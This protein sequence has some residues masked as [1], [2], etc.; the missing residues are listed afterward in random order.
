MTATKSILIVSGDCPSH[1]YACVKLATVLAVQHNITVAGPTSMMLRLKAETRKYNKASDVKNEIKTISVGSFRT[2]K[3]CNIRQVVDPQEYSP[4]Q[5]IKETLFNKDYNPF[6]LPNMLENMMDDQ[7]DTF[8]KI[9]ELL[10]MYDLVYAVHS[11]APTVIDAAETLEQEGLES[12]PRCVLF[13]SLPYEPSFCYKWLWNQARS[14]P[15]LP[16]VATYSSPNQIRKICSVPGLLSYLVQLFW[17]LLDTYLAERAWK[18]AARR[19]DN[20]RATRGLSPVYDGF[21]YYWMKYPVLSL[22]GMKPY[23]TDEDY[24][25]NSTTVVGSIQSAELSDLNRLKDWFARENFD[26]SIIY[27]G[28]GTGTQLS[29]EESRNLALLALSCDGTKYHLLLSLQKVDQVRLRDVFDQVLGKP[30]M[31]DEDDGVL[32]Y[33]NGLLRIDCDVPQENLLASKKVSMFIS[34]MGFG[35]FTEAVRGGVPMVSYPAGCDQWFNAE[36]AVEAG[37][38]V[39]ANKRMK[40]LTE[41]V[42]NAIDDTSLGKQSKKL[43]LDAAKNDSNMV[44]LN[45]VAQELGLEDDDSGHTTS[46]SSSTISEVSS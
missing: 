31:N 39:K 11:V 4:S 22:G 20:R 46:T 42:F 7:V 16:H 27:A 40:E 41:T 37:I 8:E 18:M 19:N 26:S 28:F 43:A 9:K 12:V 6:G 3:F 29:E 24:I 38:A 14:L 30:T 25:S 13:S 45:M 34:H 1:P 35:G 44:I 2:V 36:R 15:A 17:M 10:P 32:E 23:I 21:R 5:I 33:M